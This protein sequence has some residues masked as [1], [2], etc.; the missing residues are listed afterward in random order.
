MLTPEEMVRQQLIAHLIQHCGVPPTLIAT[1]KAVR[2]GERMRRFDIGIWTT[3]GSIWL[4]AECKSPNLALG[5]FVLDQVLSYASQ[6]PCQ[7]LLISNGHSNLMWHLGK[8]G[9]Q[10]LEWPKWK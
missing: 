5:E 6:L 8:G 3:S 9:Q 1:E 10:I 7:F 2:V 4:L